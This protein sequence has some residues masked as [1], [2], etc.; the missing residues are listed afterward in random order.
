MTRAVLA[1]LMVAAGLAIAPA[2]HA[3]AWERALERKGIAP[4]AVPNPIEV[5]PRVAETARAWAGGGGGEV[6]QLRRL[7]AALY[8]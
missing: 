1:P 5:T 8:D 6:D 4:A 7:Q 3:D 2:S